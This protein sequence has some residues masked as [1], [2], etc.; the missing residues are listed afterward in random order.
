MSY[1]R[2]LA[3]GDVPVCGAGSMVMLFYASM[4]ARRVS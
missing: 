1:A 2:A 3:T 4:A